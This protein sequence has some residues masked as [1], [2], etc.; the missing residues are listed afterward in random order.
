[1]FKDNLVQM[2]KVLQLTQEDIAEKL[3]VTRQSVAKWEAGE[4]IPDLDKCKQLADIFGVSLD[5]LANY[6]PED[7]LGLGVPPKGK[8][9]F[10]LVTVGDKGQIVIPAKARKIFEISTGDQLV[11]LGDEGQGLALVKASNFL[12]LANI[13]K[14]LRK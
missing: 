2:R 12:S 1:M 14:N 4:S 11:V 3:G 5:D 13:V 6:E 9:L 7:N 8:H 10:G